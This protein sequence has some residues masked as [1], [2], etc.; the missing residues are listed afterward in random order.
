MGLHGI[1]LECEL[2]LIGLRGLHI[3]LQ[4]LTVQWWGRGCLSI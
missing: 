4:E 2:S 3:R 1:Q